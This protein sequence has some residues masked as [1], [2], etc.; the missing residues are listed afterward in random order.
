MAAIFWLK[1]R[2]GWREVGRGVEVAADQPIAIRWATEADE[3][4]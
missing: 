3:A 2:A 4:A 1:T